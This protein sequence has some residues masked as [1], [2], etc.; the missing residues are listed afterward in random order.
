MLFIGIDPGGSGAIAILDEFGKPF[1]DK[2]WIKTS[3]PPVDLLRFLDLARHE[4]DGKCKAIL[5]KV[6]AMPSQGVSSTFKFGQSFGMLQGLLTGS[7]IPWGLCTPQK[8]QRQIGCIWPSGKPKPTSTQKKNLNKEVA[9]R[10]WPDE[11]ITHA[12]ADAMLI[13]EYCRLT[14][15]SS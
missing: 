11:K 9:Q 1:G 12:K 7:R 15:I 2:S 14:N 13:A 8:W 3:E 10:I 6:G 4:S 5:E